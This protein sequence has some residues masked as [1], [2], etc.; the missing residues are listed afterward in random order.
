MVQRAYRKNLNKTIHYEIAVTGESKG[1][2]GMV[3]RT[4]AKSKKNAR[5]EP[6]AIDYVVRRVDGAWRVQDIVTE[7]SSLV[8]NYRRQFSRIIKKKGFD[9]LMRRMKKKLGT[10]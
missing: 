4:V 9:D 6:I 1:N 5:E 8:N 3:V 10:G 7:G 2:A